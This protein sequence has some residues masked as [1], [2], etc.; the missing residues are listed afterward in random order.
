VFKGNKTL[1]AR[2]HSAG[3]ASGWRSNDDASRINA[4]GMAAEGARQRQGVLTPD[5]VTNQIRRFFESRQP[6]GV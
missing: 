2:T 4:S 5:E 6:G 3:R 1:G